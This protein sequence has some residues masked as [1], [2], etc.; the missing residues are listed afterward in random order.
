MR[1]RAADR[2][3]R[4]SRG[5]WSYDYD[6]ERAMDDKDRLGDKLRDKGKAAED[7][8]IAE[9]ERKRLERRK[10]AEA[11]AASG[12]GACPRDGTKL[13]AHKHNGLT[14]DMCPTCHG[15]WLDKGEVAIAVKQGN[16]TAVIHWVRSLFEH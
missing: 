5:G 2:H 8:F 3:E 13:I 14:I 1:P 4:H 15:M 11:A 12:S 9:Q 10:L 6:K 16:E 7:L